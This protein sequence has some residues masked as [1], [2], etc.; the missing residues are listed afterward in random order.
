MRRSRII[1][2]FF[3]AGLLVLALS[4]FGIGYIITDSLQERDALLRLKQSEILTTAQLIAPLVDKSI[5][6]AS[7]LL[8]MVNSYQ[9]T[10][11]TDGCA[12]D[13]RLENLI[14]QQLV[15]NQ[16]V[17]NLVVI[18]A[19]GGV[20]YELARREDDSDRVD[21]KSLQKLESSGLQIISPPHKLSFFNTKDIVLR[22]PLYSPNGDFR[23][24]AALSIRN[25]YLQQQLVPYMQEGLEA[26]ALSDYKGI[27]LAVA[28][29][30]YGQRSGMIGE[31][32]T[33]LQGFEMLSL[34][35]MRK[36]GEYWVERDD[37]LY[38]IESLGSISAQLVAILDL[39]TIEAYW[40]KNVFYP[41]LI[42]VA[43]IL[44]ITVAM[45][46]LLL[47]RARQLLHFFEELESRLQRSLV[48]IRQK[49]MIIH[50]QAKRK[51][52][53]ALLIDLAHHWR[54]PLNSA[55]IE[56]Q[57]IEDYLSGCEDDAKIKE[58]IEI[59]TNELRTLSKTITKLTQFYE[60]K[61]DNRITFQEG[62]EIVTDLSSELLRTGGIVLH[63]EVD[64]TLEVKAEADEW[65]D[66]LSAFFMNTR[67]IIRHK[68]L[69]GANLYLSAKKLEYESQIIIEDDL[70]GIEPSLLPDRLFDAYVTTLFK[71]R[72]KGLGLYIVK[73]IVVYR[74]NGTITA[75]NTGRGAKFVI[76]VPHA[77]QS[78]TFP[79]L[80][81]KA[82]CLSMMSPVHVLLWTECFQDVLGR[83][84]LPKMGKKVWSFFWS[85]V[86]ISSSPISRCR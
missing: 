35:D 23:G 19:K 70:G 48:E 56:I 66:L 52:L 2:Q 24:E 73:N 65:I 33:D 76:R 57:N 49:D 17:G 29:L 72:D 68:M 82:S 80:K 47:M 59:A 54:Q 38:L 40:K 63:T 13:E 37:A 8:E 44:F 6:Q 79:H 71:T 20:C 1:L 64:D 53:D 50:E 74:L 62:L 75:E 83:C 15:G 58:L 81:I 10:M 78:L 84:G 7:A 4:A 25:S 61:A 5:D 51:A 85:I 31:M 69:G 86:L 27:V 18:D 45:I 41:M 42:E 36:A 3:T 30:D 22:L 11:D 46:V 26:I 34:P 67:E 28:H 14:G 77:C 12:V 32:L 16:W 9:M 55:S 21:A 43:L 60:Q 39:D